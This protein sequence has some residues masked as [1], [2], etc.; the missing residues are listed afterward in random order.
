MEW[1]DSA[2]QWYVICLCELQASLGYVLIIRIELSFG[3]GKKT[4][5]SLKP[6]LI[7]LIP[8]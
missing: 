7:S 4:M 1:H 8:G 6:K 2:L 3:C 5:V